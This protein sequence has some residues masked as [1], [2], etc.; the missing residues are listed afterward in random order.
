MSTTRTVVECPECT[1][2]GRLGIYTFCR[3]CDGSGRVEMVYSVQVRATGVGGEEM[4]IKPA[5]PVLVR[6]STGTLS[7]P[8][9]ACSAFAGEKAGPHQVHECRRSGRAHR[10][11]PRPSA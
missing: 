6:R 2:A 3:A 7:A 10:H 9:A 4:L 1:E 5:F 8:E 11:S